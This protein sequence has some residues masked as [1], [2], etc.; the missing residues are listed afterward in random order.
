M[1][2]RTGWLANGLKGK[3]HYFTVSP[4]SPQHRVS[5]CGR[6]YHHFAVIESTNQPF[7]SY[8]VHI[9]ERDHIALHS[10]SGLR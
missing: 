2:D 1:D 8:C 5:L 6:K 4:L 9:A 10:E 7:C 3:T